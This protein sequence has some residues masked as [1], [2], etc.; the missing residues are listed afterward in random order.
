MHMRVLR[1]LLIMSIGG[2]LFVLVRVRMGMRVAV[3]GIAVPMFV[4][5]GVG[6]LVAVRTTVAHRVLLLEGQ[7]EHRQPPIRVNATNS[8][9][10]AWHWGRPSGEGCQPIHCHSRD[11]CGQQCQ[12]ER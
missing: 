2:G 3:H 12:P 11:P 10:V 6:M 9:L 4:R 8:A 1:S 7:P 5:M